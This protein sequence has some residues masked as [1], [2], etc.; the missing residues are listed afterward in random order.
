MINVRLLDPKYV[1]A[2]K[3]KPDAQGQTQLDYHIKQGNI[4]EQDGKYYVKAEG[5]N[6]IFAQQGVKQDGQFV[7]FKQDEKTGIILDGKNSYSVDTKVT[8]V[9]ESATFDTVFADTKLPETDK[10]ALKKAFENAGLGA[11]GNIDLSS[12]EAQN[13]MAKVLENFYKDKRTT[14]ILTQDTAF[15]D[16]AIEQGSVTKDKDGNYIVTNR[17]ELNKLLKSEYPDVEQE[18][19]DTKVGINTITINTTKTETV[20]TKQ[21][22][23]KEGDLVKN[24]A[25]RKTYRTAWEEKVRDNIYNPDFYIQK[26]EIIA[27]TR[28]DKEIAKQIGKITKECDYGDPNAVVRKYLG[29]TMKDQKIVFNDESSNKYMDSVQFGLAKDMIKK[30]QN[31]DENDKNILLKV[32]NSAHPNHKVNNFDELTV[33]QRNDAIIQS[34]YHMEVPGTGKPLS[35][36]SLIAQMATIDVMD[37]RDDKTVKKDNEWFVKDQAKRQLGRAEAQQRSDRTTTYWSKD[38]SNEAKRKDG[39]ES[40]NIHTPLSKSARRLIENAPRSFCDEVDASEWNKDMGPKVALK[41]SNGKITG[42]KYFKY[43]PTRYK[44]FC[45]A[46]VNNADPELYA[47]DNNLTLQEARQ[48]LFE[49]M[50]L[51]DVNG[52][53]ISFEKALGI[54]A[55]D[56]VD[57]R[58]VNAIRDIVQDQGF[59]VDKNTTYGKRLLEYLKNAGIGAGVGALT[60]GLGT[61]LSPVIETGI[62]AIKDLVIPG[63][64]ITTPGYHVEHSV[65]FTFNGETFNKTVVTDIPAETYTTQDQ[66]VQTGGD[67]YR[68]KGNNTG[69][70]M[71]NAAALGALS[72]LLYS[73]KTAG[74]VQERGRGNDW[75]IDY[76]KAKIHENKQDSKVDLNIPQ[77]ETIEIRSN[78]ASEEIGFKPCKLKARRVNSHMNRAET[79]ESMVAK[80]YDVQPGSEDHKKLMEYIKTFNNVKKFGG[81]QYTSDMIFNLPDRIPVNIL[82]REIE[83]AA[84][85]S[86]PE[87]RLK[88]DEQDIP[89]GG[90]NPSHKASSTKI[91]GQNRKTITL[92]TH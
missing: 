63:T 64:S 2:L 90:K 79:M 83:R 7:T 48:K 21:T 61:V 16:K 69:A 28:H 35:K 39:K 82:G 80:Y 75:T 3:K 88:L 44:K 45:D 66:T 41:D 46:L 59:N 1:E 17:D 11:D 40:K 87:T 72:G 24:K 58:E 51:Y 53:P 33:D 12:T 65:N 76:D 86:D 10:E 92:R 57:N 60:A 13:K 55:N 89:L 15:A 91:S 74:G 71:R 37:G 25:D 81:F 20:E 5:D 23:I 62:T 68:T 14:E 29:I 4:F 31:P 30:F 67:Q 43:D 19:T 54:H 26:E 78:K 9:T 42:Y 50:A 36:E 47:K 34:F 32:Y 77:W 27:K 49:D 70:A 73:T 56:K 38:A 52:N 85:P 22:P 6:A 84:D 18:P 8:K